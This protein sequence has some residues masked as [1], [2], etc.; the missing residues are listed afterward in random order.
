MLSTIYIYIYTIHTCTYEYISTHCFTINTSDLSDLTV[1][2]HKNLWILP[3]IPVEWHW[4]V[5]WKK[6]PWSQKNTPSLVVFGLRAVHFRRI[7]M[8]R[9]NRQ[10]FHHEIYKKSLSIY[11]LPRKKW[12]KHGE[13]HIK[14]WLAKTWFWLWVP[15]VHFEGSS[16]KIVIFSF[17]GNWRED[18]CRLD[19]FQSDGFET[20]TKGIQPLSSG[21]KLS[22]KP[23][24]LPLEVNAYGSI[25][26]VIP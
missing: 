6:A 21:R 8:P 12:V 7:K 10:I 17:S 16:R 25:W 24:E 26:N 19:V 23:V 2:Q 4:P 22:S 11:I 5:K 14:I 1:F 3:Q 13:T 9:K 18:V 20:A 15:A